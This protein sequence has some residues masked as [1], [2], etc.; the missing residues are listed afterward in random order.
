MP[1]CAASASER[2]RRSARPPEL[3]GQIGCRA[4]PPAAGKTRTPPAC[5]N[6]G[7]SLGLRR[8]V[9]WLA[10]SVPQGPGGGMA[11]AG[12]LKSRLTSLHPRA[13][14]RSTSK[15]PCVQAGLAHRFRAASRTAMHRIA[16]PT[17]T[18]TDTGFCALARLFALTERLFSPRFAGLSPE[19]MH[20]L[21][22]RSC[23]SR[24][25]C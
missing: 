24:A 18:T 15:I 4:R 17:D 5:Y 25:P 6:F 23:A 20:G 14:K 21:M 10:R 9:S 1:G 16:E 3:E 22:C 2:H 13:P 7:Y 12:E 11:N 19:H 8:R